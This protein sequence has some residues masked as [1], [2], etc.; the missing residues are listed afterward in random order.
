M[1][2]CVVGFA[3]ADECKWLVN[4]YNDIYRLDL[5]SQFIDQCIDNNTTKQGVD[6]DA[7]LRDMLKPMSN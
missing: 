4:E 6:I 5:N 7:L 2:L 1:W 3:K